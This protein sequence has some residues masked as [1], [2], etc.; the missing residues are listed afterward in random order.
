MTFQQIKDAIR[1]VLKDPGSG[2]QSGAVATDE[3][4]YQ[5]VNTIQ[6]LMAKTLPPAM[7]Y[8]L[9]RNYVYGY[10]EQVEVDWGNTTV[11]EFSLPTDTAGREIVAQIYDA[12]YRHANS[13][14][15]SGYDDQPV[16]LSPLLSPYQMVQYIQPT[17]FNPVAYVGYYTFRT[18][19]TPTKPQIILCPALEQEDDKFI[20]QFIRYP[21]SISAD[22]LNVECDLPGGA[23]QRALVQLAVGY[24]LLAGMTPDLEAGI[25]AVQQ[26][27]NIL[28]QH[29]EALGLNWRRWKDWL[30]SLNLP[31]APGQQG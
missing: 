2:L 29:A 13:T 15:E 22:N 8:T 24:I 10:T 21:T 20:I 12:V 1:N 31:V 18:G 28:N 17:Y 11:G 16:N 9:Q 5:A 4:L 30:A 19:I 14:S 23:V 26:G 6:E 25:R 3:F 7:L 27:Q